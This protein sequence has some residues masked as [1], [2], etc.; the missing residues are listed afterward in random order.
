M[1]NQF[2]AKYPALGYLYQIRYALYLLLSAREEGKVAIEILDDVSWEQEGKP[3]ELLQLKHHVTKS[4]SLTDSSPDLWKTIRV[5]SSHIKVGKVLLPDTILMLV[6]TASASEGS[7]AA[8]LRPGTSPEQKQN[9]YQKM[10]IVASKSENEDLKDA[11]D[12]FKNLSEQHRRQLVDAIVIIDSTKNIEDISGEIKQLLIGVR[13]NFVNAVY[14]TLEGWWLNLIIQSLISSTEDKQKIPRGLVVDK[15]ASI[16]DEYKPGFLP[17]DYLHENP[18][19]PVDTLSDSQLYIQQLRAIMIQERRIEKAVL[20]YYRAFNQIGRWTRF[21]LLVDNEL[22]DYQT[23]L[24]D[25]WERYCD[26]LKDRPGYDDST[27]EKCVEIGKQVYNWMESEADIRIREG[28][29]EQYVMRGSFHMLA[30][31]IPPRIFWHPKFIEQLQQLLP[32]P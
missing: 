13:F 31:E 2:S 32:L 30:D 26:R 21:N 3:V 28:V 5:W 18:S 17:I 1:T 7:I 12:A 6:T 23:K 16:N 24:A 11:F 14:E 15:I 25:E 4:A 27:N 10:V 9:A 29:A 22:E 20:D 8:L 19:E